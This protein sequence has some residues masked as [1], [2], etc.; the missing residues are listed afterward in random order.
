MK[1]HLDNFYIELEPGIF[2]IR[3]KYNYINKKKK[4]T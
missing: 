3:K 1:S 4:K 2:L